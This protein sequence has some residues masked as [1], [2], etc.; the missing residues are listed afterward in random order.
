MH[1][2]NV[3]SPPSELSGG[4][5]TFGSF[6]VLPKCQARTIRLWAK[7]LKRVPD[8]RLLI[9]AKPLGSAKMRKRL[10]E[11]F[12]NLGVEASRLDLVPLIPA[13]SSHLQAYANMDVG[14]DPFPYAGTTTTCE[15]LYMGVPVVTMGVKPENGDHAH[16]VGTTLLTTIGHEELIAYTEEEYVDKAVALATDPERLSCIRK[17]LRNDMMSSPLGQGERY[18]KE[19]EKMFC[20][21]W[22]ERGGC[23]KKENTKPDA[24][25]AEVASDESEKTKEKKPRFFV[26]QGN[27]CRGQVKFKLF[28]CLLHYLMFS[29]IYCEVVAT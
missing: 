29:C 24:K 2:L 20:D 8:S 17:N 10:E 15:A 22:V 4:I 13:T 25:R 5:I 14:L 1:L 28:H 7:I 9:K 27:S 3:A 12:E 6:N 19:V 21:M 11:Q 23:I 16:N 18:V 26:V